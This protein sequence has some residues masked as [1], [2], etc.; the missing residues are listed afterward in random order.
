MPTNKT[1]AK[2]LFFEKFL[3]LATGQNF[4]SGQFN[5]IGE[6]VITLE[7]LYNIREGLKSSSDTLPDRMLNESTFDGIEGGVPLESMLP[8]YY[9]LRGWDDQ[10][11]PL[12]KTVE[13]LGIKT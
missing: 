13:R 3:S 1:S 10:G 8:S 12:T 11:V 4:S 2:L 9:K 7:R 6:R 5:Q